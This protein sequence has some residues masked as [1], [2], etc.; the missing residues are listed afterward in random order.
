MFGWQLGTMFGGGTANWK[1]GGIGAG[2]VVA[3]IQFSLKYG[4]QTA[5]AVS[6]YND[7]LSYLPRNKRE[8]N[9]AFSNNKVGL[10]LRF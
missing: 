5:Q 7:G 9:I 4:Q 8:L 6:L 10:I 1:V 2:L 3:S